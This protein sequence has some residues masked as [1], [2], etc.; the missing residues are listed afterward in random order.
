MGCPDSVL[1]ICPECGRELWFQSKG[2]ACLLRDYTLDNAPDDVMSDINRHAP[3]H[4][5]CWALVSVKD[6]KAVLSD[7][8]VDSALF[9][10]CYSENMNAKDI[11]TIPDE[12]EEQTMIEKGVRIGPIKTT[13][14][15]ATPTSSVLEVR[16]RALKTLIANDPD[17]MRLI[18]QHGEMVSRLALH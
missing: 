3:Y 13:S 11:D 2:G 1:V 7:F 10:P 6:R 15:T 12:A 8:E 17:V 14:T 16:A 4:C 5:E 18:A 9:N